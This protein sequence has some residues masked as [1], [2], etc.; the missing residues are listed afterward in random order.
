MTESSGENIILMAL[1][2]LTREDVLTCAN[3][4]GMAEEQ[5]TEDVISLVKERVSQGL[6]GW[7]EEVKGMVRDAIKCPLGLVCSPSCAWREVGKCTLP[8]EIK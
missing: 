6:G 2:A 3:E 5:I 7:R 4:L 8:R 1:L